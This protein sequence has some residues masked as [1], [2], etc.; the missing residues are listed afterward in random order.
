MLA[1][2]CFIVLA[3][4]VIAFQLALAAGA[5][6]GELTMGGKFRG[7]LSG[8]MRAMALVSALLLGVLVL[9]VAVRAG[10]V[11]PGWQSRSRPAAWG[12]VAYCVLGV[13][14]NALTPSRKE[15][16]LWLPVVALMLVS[17]SFVAMG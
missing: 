5:P 2:Y 13:V 15:R 11:L 14:A 9:I 7:Q 16:I 8:P 6:W 1:A 10:L 3:L 17:S 12:V 4:F